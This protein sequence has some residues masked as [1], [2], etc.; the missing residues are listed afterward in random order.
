MNKLKQTIILLPLLILT[1]CGEPESPPEQI[2]RPVKSIIVG[3]ANAFVKRSFPG[4]I[5]ATHTSNLAFEVPGKLIEFPIKEGQVVSKEQLLAKIDPAQYQ[6]AVQEA[7]ARYDFAK[8]ELDRAKPLVKKNFISRSEYDQKRT[9]LNVAEANLNTA[10]TNLAY[11]QIIAP[12]DGIIA[13][14]LV[15]NYENVQA[16]QDV[17]VLQD[18]SRVDIEIYVPEVIMLHLRQR[19]EHQDDKTERTF[20][21]FSS[22]PQYKFPVKL[23]EFSSEADPETQTYRV[24]FI[25]DQPKNLNVLPGMSTTLVAEIPD[26]SSGAEAFYLIPAASVFTNEQNQPHVWKIDTNSMTIHATPVTV[27]RLSGDMIHVTQGLQPGDHIVSAGANFLH[28]GEKVRL[29]E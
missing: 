15:E 25:M 1:A 5:L 8:V 20:I 12:F 27:T 28:E 11:T 14:K 21:T 22:T 9:Q 2:V 26:Y 23:K 18:I 10:K 29:M 3:K 19:S 4:K 7:Q 17:V 13:N 6:D 16:K 24:T